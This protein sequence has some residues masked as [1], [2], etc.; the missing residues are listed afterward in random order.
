[1]KTLKLQI[2]VFLTILSF[3]NLNAQENIKLK[4]KRIDLAYY[5][6]DG[7]SSKIMLSNY[8]QI[9]Q[10]GK[11]TVQLYGNKGLKFYQYQ[12]SNEL[13]N[14]INSLIID[15]NSLKKQLV[16]TKLDSGNHYAGIYNFIAFDNQE[17][18]F[19][20]PYM[21]KAFNLIFNQLEDIVFKQ[22]ENSEIDNP[23]FKLE[24]MEKRVLI[25]HKKS[26]Y[27]PK[28]EQPPRMK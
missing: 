6:L 5:E 24:E 1:M 10:Y 2:L 19:V 27:L 23:K 15:K 13:M 7:N 28:I 4:S 9:N 11:V 17:L 26:N 16:K 12:L 20:E 18:C 14:Q 8:A 3:N 21:S 22:T 25:E